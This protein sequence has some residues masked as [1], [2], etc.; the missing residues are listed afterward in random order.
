MIN[1][2]LR[3]LNFSCLASFVAISPIKTFLTCLKCI[4]HLINGGPIN[5][6]NNQCLIEAIQSMKTIQT[7]KKKK[8]I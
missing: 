3:R 4:E 6:L 2:G 7:G 8:K 1:A 5:H